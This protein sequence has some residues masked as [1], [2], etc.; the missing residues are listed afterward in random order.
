MVHTVI[1]DGLVPRA[2]VGLLLPP[3]VPR[4]VADARLLARS[5]LRPHDGLL[6]ALIVRFVC[7]LFDVFMYA[8]FAW[9][10]PHSP[11]VVYEAEVEAQTEAEIG[12]E[13]KREGGDEVQRLRAMVAALASEN[14]ALKKTLA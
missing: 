1:L 12:V 11:S 5:L 2:R 10:P 4:G 13:G 14:A 7:V 8:R 9:A 3:P 6:I